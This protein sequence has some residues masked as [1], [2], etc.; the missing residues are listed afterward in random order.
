MM[1]KPGI[2]KWN[3]IPYNLQKIT[4]FLSCIVQSEA[5]ESAKLNF[6]MNDDRYLDVV[7]LVARHTFARRINLVIVF[8]IVRDA[9][10][11]EIS[12]SIESI[13]FDGCSVS[14]YLIR[15]ISQ[16]YPAVRIVR[17]SMQTELVMI[18]IPSIHLCKA[19]S[20]NYTTYSAIKNWKTGVAPSQ[21]WSKISLKNVSKIQR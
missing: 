13:T 21:D 6:I 9:D 1:P 8:V 18:L 12:E 7:K 2:Q 5:L 4:N 16:Q 14:R 11:F 20:T 17:V 3:Y 19:W 10:T 15:N